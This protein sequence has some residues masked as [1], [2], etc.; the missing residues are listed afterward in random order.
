MRGYLT[1]LAS[2]SGTSINTYEYYVGGYKRTGADAV[3]DTDHEK[4]LATHPSRPIVF[5][6][7]PTITN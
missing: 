1:N 6:L 5:E 4:A 7:R 2:G 3:F